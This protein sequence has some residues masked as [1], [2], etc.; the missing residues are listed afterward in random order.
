MRSLSTSGLLLL[1]AALLLIIAPGGAGAQTAP[2]AHE[3]DEAEERVAELERRTGRARQDLEATRSE[4]EALDRRLGA[5]NAA[6]A[7]ADEEAR[8]A[9]SAAESARAEAEQVRR[10]LE[11]AEAQLAD[12]RERLFALARDSYKH[13]VT[14]NAPI[15][16]TFE[17]LASVEDPSELADTL[18]MLEV[19]LG[20]RTTIVEESVRLRRQTA[21]LSREA[22]RREQRRRDELDRAAAARDRAAQRHAEVMALIDRTD[23]TVRHHRQLVARLEDEQAAARGQVEELEEEARRAAAAARVSVGPVR[24]GLVTVGGITVAAS[25]GPRLEALLEAARA[26]GIT[27]G[28]SGYRSSETTA[29]LRRAN[30]CPDV[31][32]SPSSSCRVPT[33]RPGESMHE[34]G[35]AVDFTYQGRTIC[36]PSPPASCRGNAAFDWLAAN[37]GRYGLHVNSAE[38]WHWSTN[39]N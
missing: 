20:E 2:D 23:E 13:G 9:T 4:L 37:A 3:I 33:A 6:L 32:E 35:L 10:Q 7:E 34:R 39:G 31:H 22:R 38:A 1:L 17:W 36:Y 14:V 18:H 16:D 28:G 5:A 11:A 15:M 12:N 29:R 21:E 30:G 26:D 24:G 27:L 25:L 8:Q 19:V